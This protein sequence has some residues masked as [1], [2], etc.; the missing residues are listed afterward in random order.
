MIHNA[1]YVGTCFVVPL[2]GPE[3][4]ALLQQGMHT[5]GLVS[6]D[7]F[8]FQGFVAAFGFGTYCPVDGGEEACIWVQ[9]LSVWS[10]FQFLWFRVQPGLNTSLLL[11]A[12]LVSEAGPQINSL[13][14]SIDV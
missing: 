1:L 11:V 7:S 13:I 10:G 14:Y 9:I 2:W 4:L 12:K 3:T 8:V 5:A 6:I